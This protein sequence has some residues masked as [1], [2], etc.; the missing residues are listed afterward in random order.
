MRTSLLT[1]AVAAL[2]LTAA[3]G[4]SDEASPAATVTV[5]APASVVTAPPVTVPPVTVPP[6]TVPPVAPPPVATAVPPSPAAAT[7]AEQTYVMPKVTGTNLQAAQDA[8]QAAA[9]G[10]FISTSKDLSG[11]GRNQVLDRNWKVCTQTP[12][13][14]A[15]FKQSSPP[16]LGVVRVEESCP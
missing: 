5:T 10:F 15:P 12:A 16:D 3:C 8:I 14:G 7:P 4:G 1:C 2:A 11:Q 13:A 6:V 9:G